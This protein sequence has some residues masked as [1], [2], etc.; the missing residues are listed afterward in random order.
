MNASKHQKVS[1]TGR[2]R[3]AEL[4]VCIRLGEPPQLIAARNARTGWGGARGGDATMRR[5]INGVPRPRH[6][7]VEPLDVER[8]GRRS[9]R[10][11]VMSDTDPAAIAEALWLP[12]SAV[13]K[14]EALIQRNLVLHSERLAQRQ[15]R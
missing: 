2:I 14:L 9:G 15:F 5:F 8:G 3:G 7:A 6:G 11:V 1:L 12:P 13:A 10:V 4:E